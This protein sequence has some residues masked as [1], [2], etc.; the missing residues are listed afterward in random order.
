[1][2]TFA[3]A[4]LAASLALLAACGGGAEQNAA[5]NNAS[6]E[7]YNLAPDD[8]VADNLVGNEALDNGADANL[9]LP[10]DENAAGNAQ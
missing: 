10:V 9:A 8:L 1:M 7:L 4:A 2:K 3:K 5:A 6:D